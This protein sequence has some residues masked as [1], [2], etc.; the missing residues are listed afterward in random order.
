MKEARPI[1]LKWNLY[2]PALSGPPL[3][4]MNT[5]SNWAEFSAALS[6]W[7]WPSQNVVYSDDQGHIAY[8]AVGHVPLR[9]GYGTYLASPWIVSG[10]TAG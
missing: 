5:A 7:C 1:S 4:Q 9:P 6:N 8:H 2:D 3:Y 10:E